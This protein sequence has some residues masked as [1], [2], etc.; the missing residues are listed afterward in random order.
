VARGWWFVPLTT[1]RHTDTTRC[2]RVAEAVFAL[3]F[4]FVFNQVEHVERVDHSAAL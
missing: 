3:D 4:A 1:N 2:Q